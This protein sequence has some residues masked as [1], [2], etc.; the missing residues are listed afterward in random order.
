MT[1]EQWNEMMRLA[2]DY[3]F[4]VIAPDGTPYGTDLP[5]LDTIQ[6]VKA[7]YEA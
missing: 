6:L 7:E 1:T 5:L 2:P 3:N 4:V